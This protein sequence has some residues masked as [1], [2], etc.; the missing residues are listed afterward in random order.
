MGPFQQA[1]NAFLPSTGITAC[2]QQQL[3]S[4]GLQAALLAV[5]KQFAPEHLPLKQAPGTQLTHRMTGCECAAA[6]YSSD[7]Q[8]R[9]RT[10]QTAERSCTRRL[11]DRTEHLPSTTSSFSSSSARYCCQ[12]HAA[13]DRVVLAG[14]DDS[15]DSPDLSAGAHSARSSRCRARKY[16]LL[17]VRAGVLFNALMMVPMQRRVSSD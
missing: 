2:A 5:R 14:L 1:R 15:A 11:A 13:T 16:H 3:S 10:S 6:E 7:Q 17:R 9:H 8:S 4:E 12:V